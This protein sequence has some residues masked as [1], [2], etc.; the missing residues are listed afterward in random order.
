MCVH[1]DDPHR[2]FHRRPRDSG[3]TA[4]TPKQTT[5]HSTIGRSR[6]QSVRFSAPISGRRAFVP[7]RIHTRQSSYRYVRS[8]HAIVSLR[9]RR[10]SSTRGIGEIECRPILP[11]RSWV[12]GCM[13]VYVCVDACVRACVCVCTRWH[14]SVVIVPCVRADLLRDLWAI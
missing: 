14:I 9:G 7:L 13:C 4:A 6:I 3:G 10:R 8:E 11:N 2:R 5:P 12:V 1:A